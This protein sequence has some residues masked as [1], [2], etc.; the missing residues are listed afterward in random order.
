MYVCMYVCMY[1]GM[2]VPDV[3]GSGCA[4]AFTSACNASCVLEVIGCP[5]ADP[6]MVHPQPC[7]RVTRR[8]MCKPLTMPGLG[9]RR[10]THATEHE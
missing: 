10:N 1:V 8:A 3:A 9:L 5:G 2:Y 6:G 4:S 7:R